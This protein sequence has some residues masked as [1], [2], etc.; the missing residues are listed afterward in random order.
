M[1]KRL[2]HPFCL[3]CWFCFFLLFLLLFFLIPGGIVDKHPPG[4]IGRLGYLLWFVV[5]LDILLFFF[6][7][8]VIF[9]NRDFWV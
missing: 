5:D 1:E 8:L 2:F 9:N 3:F 6:L 4:E 7:S